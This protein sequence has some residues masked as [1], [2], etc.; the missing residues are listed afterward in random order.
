MSEPKYPDIDVQLSGEDGNAFLIIG[1]VAKALRR[2]NVED[3]E[4][5][6]FREE[7]MS[8]NYDNV[9]RAAMRWVRAR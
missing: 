2:A 6:A 9:L 7:A 5:N 8:G 1:S 4:I 3:T